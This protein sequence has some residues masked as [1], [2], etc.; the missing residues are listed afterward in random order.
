M[1]RDLMAEN[2]Y[3]LEPIHEKL[4]NTFPLGIKYTGEKG[5]PAV[6]NAIFKPLTFR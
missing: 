6:T 2:D 4:Q 3:R 5:A 1:A